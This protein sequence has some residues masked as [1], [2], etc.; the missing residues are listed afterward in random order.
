MD[1][2]ADIIDDPEQMVYA[3]TWPL[4]VD[5]S[6]T[7]KKP[8][9]ISVFVIETKLSGMTTSQTSSCACSV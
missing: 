3:S 7:A 8:L 5:T 9:D 6:E 2:N 4:N 1:F